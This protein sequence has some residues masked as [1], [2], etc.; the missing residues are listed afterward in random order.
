MTNSRAGL[1]GVLL[2][3]SIAMSGGRSDLRATPQTDAEKTIR[4]LESYG[5]G[6]TR[7]AV[8]DN[9]ETL[10]SNLRSVGATWVDAGPEPDRI[11]RRNVLALV[12]LDAAANDVWWDDVKPLLEWV[13]ARLRRDAPTPFERDWMLASIAFTGVH[14]DERFLLA[15]GCRP[16]AVCNHLQHATSRFPDEPRLRFADVFARREVNALHRR[17]GFPPE[18]LVPALPASNH[19]RHDDAMAR[20]N[21]TLLLLDRAAT[22][23]VV[24]PDARLRRGVLRYEIKDLDGSRRDLGDVIGTSTDS[25]IK[26]LAHLVLGL[27][28]DADGRIED[29]AREYAA[30]VALNPAIKS[31]AT[32]LAAHYFLTGRG[33]EASRI[34][35]VAFAADPPAPD[36]WRRHCGSCSGLEGWLADLRAMVRQ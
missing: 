28:L 6:E 17:P 20:I 23:P 33:D 11:R 31:G 36:P 34:L 22:D 30:A 3:V 32:Q 7:L 16:P 24:G 1:G 29:A 19:S 2:A 18:L 13:C 10:V 5:R 15:S 4:L 25:S 14:G 12:A 27:G 8:F 35:D 21:E 9:P 26:Y